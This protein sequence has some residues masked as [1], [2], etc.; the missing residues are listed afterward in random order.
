MKWELKEIRQETNHKFLNFFTLEYLVDNK[1]YSY[2]MASRKSK[3][4][5]Y[6]ICKS[7]RPDG[8]L[9]PCYYIDKNNEVSILLTSQFRPAVNRIITSIPAGLIDGDE[10]IFECA[11]REALEEVG[12]VIEDLELL[13]PPSFSS[14]GLSDEA[15][16]VVLARIVEFKNNSLEEFEDI[17][18]RLV[19]L[20][21]IKNMYDDD[22]YS[23]PTNVRLIIKYLLERFK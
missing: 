21:E 23:I 16:A 3:D 2:F 5:L 17:S 7:N 13:C 10:D 22:R 15:N 8:V 18:S 9:I 6:A 1:P 19:S 11:K 20:K 12:V 4:S 14:T